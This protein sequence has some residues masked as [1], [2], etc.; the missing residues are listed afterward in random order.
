MF[1]AEEAAA[2]STSVINTFDYFVLAFTLLIAIAV[3]R[4]VTAKQK[5]LFAI[6]FG[7]VSLGVFVFM[8]VVMIRGW[9]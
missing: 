3:F 9:L 5:N 4:S 6:G 7:I 8:D 2:A 1:L